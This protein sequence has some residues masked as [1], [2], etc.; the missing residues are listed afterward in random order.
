M[1]F[2]GSLKTLAEQ[3]AH[4]QARSPQATRRARLCHSRPSY[5]LSRYPV[6]KI[7]HIIVRQIARKRIV[8][9][10]LTPALTSAIP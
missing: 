3:T 10:K 8:M 2:A 1:S 6:L 7:H 4:S 5:A 9:A